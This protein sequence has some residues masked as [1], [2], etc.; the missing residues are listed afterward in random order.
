M[1]LKNVDGIDTVFH[2]AAQTSVFNQNLQQIVDDNIK[3]FI[4]INGLCVLSGAKF[5]Y[6]SSST[7]NPCN[8]TSLYGMSKAFDE[9]FSTIYDA[10]SF[11]VRLHNVYGK[12]PRQGTLLWHL[13]NRDSVTLYNKGCNLRYFTY[14]VDVIDGLVELGENDYTPQ[15]YNIFNPH[16]NMTYEFAKAV[17][18][19]NHVK[20][21]CTGRKRMFDNL[22]QRVNPHL[23][24]L[25]LQYRTIQEGIDD[26]FKNNED[27]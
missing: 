7:A 4:H 15:I 2:L 17:S 6:A 14:I 16:E 10:G 5:I 11:G 21:E 19:Y 3:A 12:N 20:I 24:N 9:Q 25:S 22:A 27:G 8:T 1:D 18:S 13:L 26:I 23:E